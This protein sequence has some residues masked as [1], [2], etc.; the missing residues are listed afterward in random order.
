MKIRHIFA[1]LAAPAA[2]AVVVL[3]SAGSA[4]AATV[5]P[6]AHHVPPRHKVAAVSLEVNGSGYE[7]YQQ[8]TALQ[9]F[10]RNH[11]QVAYTNDGYPMPGSGVWAPVMQP[12]D[13]LSFQ[14]NGTGTPYGH[15]LD[16]TSL[17]AKSP[18]SVQFKGSGTYNTD[19]SYTWTIQGLVYKDHGVAKVHFH[20]LYTGTNA[21]YTVDAHGTI[22]A[23]G[24][25][26]GT[27][28]G[29]GGSPAVHN[30]TLTWALGERTFQ[31]VLYF[32][33]PVQWASI[34]VPGQNASVVFTIPAKW[35]GAPV[36]YAGYILNLSAHNGHSPAADTYS[37]GV[38]T[39]ISA[40]IANTSPN[41]ETVEGG[42][43][44]MFRF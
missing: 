35:N 25:A 4:S 26:T 29:N 12:G 15:T 18:T 23:D 33:A 10:G 11:G 37:Q 43:I 42:H 7:L 17:T 41:G 8:W 3:G 13:S 19:K 39:T 24:S 21:G 6:A 9:G 14:L 32:R 34:S 44:F 22:A 31:Q 1:A 2:L 30:Q 16:I 36:P 38:Y 5:H 40:A 27:A 28:L 20:I